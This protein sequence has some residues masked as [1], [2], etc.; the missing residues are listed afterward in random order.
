LAILVELDDDFFEVVLFFWALVLFACAWV[1]DV[2]WFF[3]DSCAPSASEW[4]PSTKGRTIA[5]RRKRRS[6]LLTLPLD[7][8][9]ALSGPGPSPALSKTT[10]GDPPGKKAELFFVFA[11][12]PS[13]VF[14]GL[15]SKDAGKSP[16][17]PLGA[18]NLLGY[19]ARSPMSSHCKRGAA[20][21][22]RGEDEKEKEAPSIC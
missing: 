3:F 15:G 6:F 9:V 12:P 14:C 13:W 16:Q 1:E 7:P 8:L 11:T 18:D 19:N 2:G 10:S 4:A 22:E 17:S 5:P 20:R 21:W